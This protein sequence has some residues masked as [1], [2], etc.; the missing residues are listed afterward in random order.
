M[1]RKTLRIGDTLVIRHDLR[2]GAHYLYCPRPRL[3]DVE[4]F[5]KGAREIARKEGDIFLKID[6]V[7]PLPRPSAARQGPPADGWRAASGLQP[8]RTAILDLA[9]TEEELLGRMHE[10]TRYNIRLAE[11][12]GVTV[13]IQ[14]P[15]PK[16]Q[17]PFWRLL[18]D[19]ARRD[20]FSLHPRAYYEKLLAAHSDDFSNELFAAEYGGQMLALAIVNFYRGS[21]S[22]ISTGVQPSVLP[23]ATYLHGGSLREHRGVMAP[24]LLHWEIIKEARRRGFAHYDFWGID[25]ERWPGLTRFKLGF[26]GEPVRYPSSIDIVYRPVWYRAYRV[27]QWWRSLLSSS[28]HTS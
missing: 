17:V 7:R 2:G 23:V 9:G 3:S 10:K 22:I 26:G 15:S 12:K 14:V 18:Q 11:R 24:H 5:F 13:S 16:S 4:S 21:T 20:R 6:P 1:G 19:T 25:E 27:A 8:S 28:R